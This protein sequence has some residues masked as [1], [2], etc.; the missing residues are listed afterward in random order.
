LSLVVINLYL[1]D[2][3]IHDLQ[4]IVAF[5]DFVEAA[6]KMMAQVFSIISGSFN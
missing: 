6:G 2:N 1:I 3:K 4:Y 5:A